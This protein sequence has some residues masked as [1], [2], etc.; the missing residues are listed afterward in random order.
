MRLRTRWLPVIAG[1]AL[2]F[3]AVSSVVQAVGQRS[4][5]PIA[6]GLW[7]PAVVVAACWPGAYRRCLPRRDR[8]AG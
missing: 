2:A 3:V 4:W 1:L 6:E 5:G 8:Q 7:I